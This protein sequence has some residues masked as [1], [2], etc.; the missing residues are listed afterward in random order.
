MVALKLANFGGMIPAVDDRLLPE[1]AASY[2]ENTWLYYGTIEGLPNPVTVYTATDPLARK[3]YRIPKTYYDKDH[4]ED[5]WWLEFENPDTDILKSPVADDTYERFYWASSQKYSATPPMYNTKARIIAG[6]PAYKLGVPT[7]TTAPAVARVLGAYRLNASTAVFRQYGGDADLYYSTRYAL[8][9]ESLQNGQVAK[10][11]ALVRYRLT[12]GRASLKYG[13]TD[14]AVRVTIDDQG[15]VT[16]GIPPKSTTNAP[17]NPTEGTGSLETRAYVY[18]WVTGFGEESAPSPPTVY[19]SWSGDPW[20]VSFAAPDASVTTDRNITKVRIYRTI[21]GSA[22]AA[23]FFLVKELD[24]T[25]TSY[26]DAET[27]DV[28][29]GNAQLESFYWTPPPEDLDGWV[30]MPNG[31][32]AGWRENEIWFCEPYRPHA[33]PA[34]YSL[35]TEYPIVGL[36]VMGQTLIAC[37][38]ATPYAITGINPASMSMSRI[39]SLEGCLSRGSIVSTLQ[40]VLYASQNGL[41]LA[42]PGIADVVTRN[43]ITKDKWLDFL[44][45]PSLRA[46]V[47]NNAY[48]CW[49]SVRTGSF[50]PGA[51]ETSAFLQ[52]DFT[53]SR[54]GAV[55]D[56]AN[57][58]VAW[59]DLENDEPLYNLWTDP[60]SGEVFHFRNGEVQWLDITGNEPHAPFTWR[61]KIFE[62]PNR[63][64]LEAMRIWFNTPATAPALNPVPNISLVQTLAPDQYG[65]VRVYADGVHRFTREIRTSG[66]LMRLPS[67]FKATYWQIEI[68]ARINV[69]SIEAATSAKELGSV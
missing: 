60:W 56:F 35:N 65:L 19:T 62:M 49:G 52:L 48:Y 68:E 32:I 21:T 25:E 13:T 47:F 43:M 51:F 37:T 8:D 46:T 38:S 1:T 18:T 17:T 63:R 31:I 45:V 20:V 58:R 4:I 57:Q 59:T 33:W 54:N 69:T 40:G 10:Q 28:V 36:G 9:A 66:E 24:I 14:S 23:S 64:N 61:S 27:T 22:G 53:G 11:S 34:S 67:G 29:S 15:D 5:S 39:A 12:G 26:N 16:I 7:P 30:I 3:V 6:L 55:I 50:D 41:V 44:N 2:S 42:A